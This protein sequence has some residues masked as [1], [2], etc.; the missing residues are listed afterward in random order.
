MT[1]WHIFVSYA[2]ADSDYVRRLAAF[3]G[4]Q[5]FEA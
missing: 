1:S 4:S 2:H 5:G 3:L